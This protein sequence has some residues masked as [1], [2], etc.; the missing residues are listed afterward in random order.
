MVAK[1]DANARSDGKKEEKPDLK[2]VQAKMPNINGHGENSHKKGPDEEKAG[3][4]MD[5]MKE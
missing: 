2:P 1:G 3:R 5:A 4:P